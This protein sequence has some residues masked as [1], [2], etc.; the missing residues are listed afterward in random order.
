MAGGQLVYTQGQSVI[1]AGRRVVVE[2]DLGPGDRARPGLEH[3]QVLP[4]PRW[5]SV[6]MYQQVPRVL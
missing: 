4:K 1:G 2:P 6:L 5:A 3:R